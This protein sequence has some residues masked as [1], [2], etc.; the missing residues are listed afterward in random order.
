MNNL[1]WVP[2]SCIALLLGLL[3]L[4]GG[5]RQAETSFQP[6]W[7]P[8]AQL[9]VERMSLRMGERVLLVGQPGRFDELT[10]ELRSAIRLTGATDLGALSVLSQPYPHAEGSDLLSKAARA[11]PE[12]LRELLDGA[13]DLAVMLPDA[14]PTHPPYRAIQELLRQGK[15]RTIHFHWHGAYSLDGR[16]LPITDA[17]STVYQRALLETDY[18]ALSAAQKKF[19]QAARRGLI[20]VTTPSGTDLRFRIGRRPVTRQD[21]DASASRAARAR[22]LIDREIELPSGAVRVAPLEESVEGVI[23]FP[24]SLWNGQTVEGLRLRFRSG[25]VIEISA[26]TGKEAVEAEMDQAGQAGRSFR[27]FALGFN[28]LLA[29]PEK[30]PWIPYYGYGAGVV[31]LSLGDNSELGGKVSG[32]YVRWNFFVDATVRVGKKV[33]VQDGKLSLPSD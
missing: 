11:S 20:Q 6:Q 10:S 32:G 3:P 16:V 26:D 14:Q 2:L 21:G 22:N 28:P 30:D 18:A 24:P 1:R 12:E 5:S 33:W 8:L 17:I 31:R 13:F 29:I 19:E 27:E 23:A 7:Q 25:K 9:L 15:G 4:T